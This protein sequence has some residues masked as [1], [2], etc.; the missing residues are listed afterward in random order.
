MRFGQVLSR[1]ISSDLSGLIK[2]KELRMP[3]TIRTFFA[4]SLILFLVTVW[5]G[6]P[7][8]DIPR[9]AAAMFAVMA[10][11]VLPLKPYSNAMWFRIGLIFLVGFFLIKALPRAG[12]EE[13]HNVFIVKREENALR[14]GLPATAYAAMKQA[15][16]QAYPAEQRCDPVR[17]Y[18]WLHGGEPSSTFATSFDGIF[19]PG[20]YSRVVD[21]IGFLNLAGFRGGFVNDSRYNWTPQESDITRENMPYFVMYELNA[22]MAGGELCWRGMALWER[23]DGIY[24]KQINDA[25]A[26][27]NIDERDVGKKVFGVGIGEPLSMRLDP[28]LILEASRWSRLLVLNTALAAVLAT[29]LQFSWAKLRVPFFTVLAVSA[30]IYLKYPDLFTAYSILQG[31]NDGHIHE[32]YGRQILSQALQGNWSRAISGVESVYYFMPGMRYLRAMEKLFFGDTNYGYLAFLLFLPLVY[33]RFCCLLMPPV[34]GVLSG[35][36]TIPV[37]LNFAKLVNE[38]WAEPAAYGIF[39]GSVA[40]VLPA[41]YDLR[42]NRMPG[43]VG[44]LGLAFAVFLRPNLA[45]AALVLIFIALWQG[46]YQRQ[47]SSVVT[48]VL[49]FLPVLW[50]PIHNYAFG[51]EFV[52]FTSS[53]DDAGVR[54]VAP[55][56]YFRGLSADKISIERIMRHWHKQAG[57]WWRFIFFLGLVGWAYHKLKHFSFE[58]STLVAITVASYIPFLFYDSHGQHHRFGVLASLLT[59]TIA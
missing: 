17:R 20:K 28:P 34:W 56:D 47:L 38:G 59:F 31:S 32:S 19:R 29:S 35:I 1:A 57:T 18:C 26:C 2:T 15:F 16:D 33:Y 30:V 51:H 37:Y 52:I 49:G 58:V 42:S 39:L 11:V 25:F 24:G 8:N 22:A 7:I 46:Y 5:I 14:K 21:D 12:I 55:S 36:L 50:M 40:F 10:T 3:Q 43:F 27:R 9:F 54:M 45:I 6:L 13:G 44:F 41:L 23:D 53:V 48:V 4:K